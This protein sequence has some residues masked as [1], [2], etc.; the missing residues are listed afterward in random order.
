MSRLHLAHPLHA[1][2]PGA[3]FSL[4][5]RGAGFRLALVSGLI[6]V[7]WLAVFWAIS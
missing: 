6:A 4:L 2:A 1:R 5:R 3:P 7:L